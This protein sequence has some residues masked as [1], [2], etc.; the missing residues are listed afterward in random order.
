LTVEEIL[1]VVTASVSVVVVVVV[2]VAVSSDPIAC[3]SV[4]HEIATVSEQ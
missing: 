1:I 4:I 3:L 2:V